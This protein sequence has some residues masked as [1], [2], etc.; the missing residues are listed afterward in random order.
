MGGGEEKSPVKQRSE[1]RHGLKDHIESSC[2]IDTVWLLSTRGRRKRQ[3]A[4][5]S[6]GAEAQEGKQKEMRQRAERTG[7]IHDSEDCYEF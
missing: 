1:F 2:V 6:G 4:G 5:S 3:L 7:W